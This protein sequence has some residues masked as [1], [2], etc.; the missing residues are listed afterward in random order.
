MKE[1]DEGFA[2]IAEIVALESLIK[3][4]TQPVISIH[5]LR[6][7]IALFIS[8]DDVREGELNKVRDD[9]MTKQAGC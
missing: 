3:L 8:G 6:T 5:T 1:Q 2:H 4:S 7:Y 9:N